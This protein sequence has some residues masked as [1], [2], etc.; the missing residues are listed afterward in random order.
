M[1]VLI[2]VDTHELFSIHLVEHHRAVGS[3]LLE[4]L[5]RLEEQAPVATWEK[6][7]RLA[8]DHNCRWVVE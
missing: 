3:F 8:E 1:R 4:L 7:V 2:D 5:E 6:I